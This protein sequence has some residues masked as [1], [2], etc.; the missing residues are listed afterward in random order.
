MNN[1]ENLS[2]DIPEHYTHVTKRLLALY[3]EGALDKVSSIDVEPDYGYVSRI[4]YKNDEHRIINGY[5]LG[6]N[7]GA[8]SSLAKDKGHA[9]FLLRASGINCPKGAEFLLPWWAEVISPDQQKNGNT[10]LNTIDKVAGYIESE[11]DYPV[12]I[13]PVSGSKGTGV[14]RIDAPNYLDGVLEE[15]EETRVKVAVVEEAVAM[16]D[17]R[18]VVSDGEFVCAY[19]RLPL[20]VEGDGVST[21]GDL[22]VRKQDEYDKEDDRRTVLDLEDSRIVHYLGEHGYDLGSVPGQAEGVTLL[23]ISNLSAGGVPEDVSDVIHNRWIELSTKVAKQFNL[24]LCGVDL[25]CEDIADCTTDYSVLEVN[26]TPGLNIYSTLGI[27][28]R[29]VVDGL[30]LRIFNS[31]P[32]EA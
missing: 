24:R 13:K 4:N 14:H 29:N 18:V 8:A 22:M 32:S 27:K 12:Y 19:R 5:D 23:P 15:Y 16:P 9:K 2:V 7:N 28:Q 25:A 6:V 17:Y 26:G 10:E 3:E 21:I 1:P 30:F 20:M 11:L 31:A